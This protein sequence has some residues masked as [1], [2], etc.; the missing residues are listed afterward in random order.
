MLCVVC[1]SCGVSCVVCLFD[2]LCVF[3][4]VVCLGFLVVWVSWVPRV[5]CVCVW[6]LVFV[7]V[8]VLCV[9]DVSWRS[10][11]PGLSVCVCVRVF[12]CGAG[13]CDC[14][15]CVDV[16]LPLQIANPSHTAYHE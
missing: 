16:G 10:G 8:C 7:F 13:L 11:F 14:G 9:C 6:F 2:S 3:G 4:F 5:V 12:V 1:V 15:L